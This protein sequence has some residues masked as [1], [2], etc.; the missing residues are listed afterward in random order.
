MTVENVIQHG[1][2]AM[3]EYMFNGSL[4][5]ALQFVYP[6][7]NWLPWKFAQH[8]PRGFWNVKENQRDFMNWLGNVLGFKSMNNWYNVTHQTIEE[9]GGGG[10]LVKYGGSRSKL[11]PQIFPE[12]SWVLHRFKTVQPHN[13]NVKENDRYL[14]NRLG[15]KLGLKRMEDWYKVTWKEIQDNGGTH[16]LRKYGSSPSELIQKVYPEYPWVSQ[17]LQTFPKG[18]WNSEENQKDFLDWLGKKLGFVKVEDWYTITGKEI[19]EKGG[20]GL[21]R[22]Y[23]ESPFKLLQAIYPQHSWNVQR[24][25]KTIT[26]Q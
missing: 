5:T 21:I 12:H 22:K 20:S 2:K 1:G 14:V 7:H 24:F 8:V 11:L 6:E 23:R 9:K 18:Y 26:W 19:K 4:A 10:L 25:K 13:L 17:R 16:L 15:K 3:V